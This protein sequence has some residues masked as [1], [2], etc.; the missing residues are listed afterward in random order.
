[1][2]T[3]HGTINEVDSSIFASMI[4]QSQPKISE[5][6]SK[7]ETDSM[8]Q[9]NSPKVSSSPKIRLFDLKKRKEI[10]L[11]KYV[12]VTEAKSKF[13]NCLFNPR[14]PLDLDILNDEKIFK[15]LQEGLTDAQ[16]QWVK[17]KRQ[18]LIEQ[19]S[20]QVLPL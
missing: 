17:E 19:A 3:K 13:T 11:V 14:A 12:N 2:P 18:L 16:I 9:Q 5:A 10:K 7:N 4:H 20:L 8:S 15:M 1:M 6:S